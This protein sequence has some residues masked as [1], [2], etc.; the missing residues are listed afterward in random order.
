MRPVRTGGRDCPVNPRHGGL[1]MLDADTFYC[2][3]HEHDA[4]GTPAIFDAEGVARRRTTERK[5]VGK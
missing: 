3:H 2:P 5:V 4:D 1:Y